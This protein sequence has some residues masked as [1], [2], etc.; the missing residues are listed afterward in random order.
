M[1]LFNSRDLEVYSQLESVQGVTSPLDVAGSFLGIS[2]MITPTI[3]VTCNPKACH[4]AAMGG[5]NPGHEDHADQPWYPTMRYPSSPI[6]LLVGSDHDMIQDNALRASQLA[7]C[8]PIGSRGKPTMIHTL[9]NSLRHKLHRLPNS[10]VAQNLLSTALVCDVS[11]HAGGN[12]DDNKGYNIPGWHRT[13][14]SG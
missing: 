12:K 8:Q 3:T 6:R 13:C 10:Q 7:P 11:F 2:P 9:Q 14:K 5:S 4:R 1:A